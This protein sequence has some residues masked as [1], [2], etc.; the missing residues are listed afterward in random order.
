ML[1][2]FLSCILCFRFYK[3]KFY[4]HTLAAFNVKNFLF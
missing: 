1:I 2:L 4:Y 3:Y